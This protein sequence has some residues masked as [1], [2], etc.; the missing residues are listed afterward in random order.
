[1]TNRS[2]NG[3]SVLVRYYCSKRKKDWG[4]LGTEKKYIGGAPQT[5]QNSSFEIT[6]LLSG[7]SSVPFHAFKSTMIS[8]LKS[9][10]ESYLHSVLFRIKMGHIYLL[11]SIIIIDIFDLTSKKL[12]WKLIHIVIL[13]VSQCWIR[14][15][16]EFLQRIFCQDF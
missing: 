1:M 4:N 16:V 5:I 14:F 9:Q 6:E 8:S 15:S 10:L 13:A 11:I 12:L 3:F 7:P 2:R